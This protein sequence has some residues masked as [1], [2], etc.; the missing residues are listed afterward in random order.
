LLFVGD[1]GTTESI[2]KS[3][4]TGIEWANFYRP[5]DW[6][7]LEADLAFTNAELVDASTGSEVPNS[8]GRVISAGATVTWPQ[9]YFASLRLR[10]FGDIPLTED[11]SVRAGSTTL[12]NLEAGYRQK[13]WQLALEVLNLLD[14]DDSDISYYYAS[15]LPGEPAEG[16]EDIHYHP[17]EPRTVRVVATIRF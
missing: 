5:V 1:A 2:G 8:V 15:R 12:L 16:I 17:V 3:R 13:Q 4:R 10:Y 9:G 7:T 14:S 11:G 6:L